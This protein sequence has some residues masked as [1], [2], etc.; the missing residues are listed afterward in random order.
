MKVFLFLIDFV[1]TAF[2]IGLGIGLSILIG[3]KLIFPSSLKDNIQRWLFMIICGLM[4]IAFLAIWKIIAAI[5]KERLV[6]GN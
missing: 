3:T 4:I 6:N 1:G 2:A 5:I